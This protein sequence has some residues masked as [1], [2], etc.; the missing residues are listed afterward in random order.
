MPQ[1]AFEA[2]DLLSGPAARMD[3]S[4]SLLEKDIRSNEKALR[5]LN[6]AQLQSHL[7]SATG[8][9]YD[10]VKL[11]L[12]RNQ[13]Q[14]A[15]A[16]ATEQRKGLGFFASL[17]GAVSPV[18]A[19]RSRVKELGESL[20]ESAKNGGL[21]R[22]AMSGMGSVVGTAVTGLS[23]LGV[24]IAGIGAAFVVSTARAADFG[25][26][27]RRA[28]MNRLGATEGARQYEILIEYSNRYG[29]S[30]Q[31]VFG[32]FGQ[33]SRAGF[34]QNDALALMQAAGD[35][36][37]V[38]GNEA[39]GRVVT[40]MTQMA[41]KG[42]TQMEE[43]MQ[44]AEA[45]IPLGEVLAQIAHNRGK[46][47]TEVQ[48]LM[49]RGQITGREGV[50]AAQAVLVRQFSQGGRA[51]T[52]M[53][54]HTRTLGGAIDLITA[55]WE[56]FKTRVGETNAFAPVTAFLGKVAE[57]MD[58]NTESGRRFQDTLNKM[59]TDFFGAVGQQDPVKLFQDLMGWMR[60]AGTT[61]T[62]LVNV[63]K[64][65]ADAL[66]TVGDAYDKYMR[67]AAG[68]S[69]GRSMPQ[70]ARSVEGGM[71]YEQEESGFFGR[72]FNGSRHAAMEATARQRARDAIAPTA[73]NPAGG[74]PNAARQ[75][76]VGGIHVNL[77]GAA[78]QGGGATPAE[79]GRQIADSAHEQLSSHLNSAAASQGNPT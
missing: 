23:A 44:G 61:A 20:Q 30:L 49:Q 9:K 31:D 25:E 69:S 79:V 36:S 15:R 59:F 64:T 42:K 71:R 45:G 52:G 75:V 4:L 12:Q 72:I 35:A 67:W 57:L 33:L 53:V 50:I 37:G 78:I 8:F 58:G 68:T 66:K 26:S 29:K 6:R 46:T 7:L 77:D 10:R 32:Q 55:R 43:L 5:D 13:L 70:S 48:K 17:A 24:G 28:L 73:A 27:Q 56:I 63:L 38:L 1:W 18:Q 19:L 14:A 40:M 62:T 16:L 11:D 3:R 60:E 65:I 2:L 22:S 54:A 74:P 51:G 34:N 39:A 41:A 76:N 47:L 21:F